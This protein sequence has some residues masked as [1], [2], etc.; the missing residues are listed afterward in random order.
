[1]S[2]EPGAAARAPDAREPRAPLG[3]WA[4]V[5][6]IVLVVLALDIALLWWLTERY[7]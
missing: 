6:A 1:V 4:R 5:Y 7:R 2:G 3:S